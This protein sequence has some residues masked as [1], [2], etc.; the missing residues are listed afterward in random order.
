LREGRISVGH[1]KVVL[2]LASE[3][4]QRTAASRI[5]KDGWSVR[6]TEQW[7]GRVQ[8]QGSGEADGGSAKAKP[9]RDLHVMDI[10]NSLRERLGTKVNLRYRQG[11][12]SLEIAFFSDDELERI[13]QIL[14][15]STE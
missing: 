12:G 5:L 15:I 4:Q 11:K 7:V 14:G 3:K 10:E 13:L 1:A 8:S 2:G 9:N 6:Q